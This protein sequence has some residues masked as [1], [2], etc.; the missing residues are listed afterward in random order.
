MSRIGKKAISVPA[1]VKVRHDAAARTVNVEGPKGKLSFSYRPEVSVALADGDKQIH[2]TV[3]PAR[4]EDRQVRAFWGTT[5]ARIQ[6]MVNGVATGYS[7]ALE[8][9]GV[10]WNAKIQ[11]KNLL[12]SVGY[13]DPISLPIPDGVAVTVDA[14]TKLALSGPDKQAVGEFASIVRS[15]RKPE[16]YNGKGIKYANEVI[17]K[18]QGKAF[19]S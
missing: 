12:L 9:V 8:V 5:R 19:G 10:G 2:C 13:S 14:G 17:Q 18:K 15:Q 3:D 11:G 6:G 7:K 1:G 4:M 16:P